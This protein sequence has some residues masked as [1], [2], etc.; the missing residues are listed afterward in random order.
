M[1]AKGKPIAFEL[2]KRFYDGALSLRL[3]CTGKNAALE[4]FPN[5]LIKLF[6]GATQF[7][8]MTYIQREIVHFRR[9]LATLA[10]SEKRQ[11]ASS[12]SAIHS[13]DVL[14]LLLVVT[15]PWILF[16]LGQGPCK[17]ASAS[18]LL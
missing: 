18:L 2:R 13:D 8:P 10:P 5:I 6:A 16:G 12:Y 11:G 9:V 4:P 17:R 14:D 7:N 3:A 1:L 15:I